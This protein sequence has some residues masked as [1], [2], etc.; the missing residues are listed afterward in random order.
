MGIPREVKYFCGKEYVEV[1]L[2]EISAKERGKKMR[3]PKRNPSTENQVKENKKRRLRKLIRLVHSNFTSDDY[4]LTLTCD[5]EHM[6][7]D[8]KEAQQKMRNFLRRVNRRLKRDG[9]T[10][11]RYIATIETGKKGT[12]FHYHFIISC[13]LSRNE[14]ED[15]WGQ[16]LANASRLQLEKVMLL[17]AYLLK[18]VREPNEKSWHCSRNLT[19]PVVRKN[20]WK[21]SHRQLENMAKNTED[22]EMWEKLYPGYE[23]IEA[24]SAYHEERGWY[25]T[26]RMRKKKGGGRTR[27]HFKDRLSL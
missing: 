26:L 22:W 11:A 15:I 27:K 21:Y 2:F 3:E 6:P 4:Y 10:P 12:N 25:V 14:L 18:E 1:D 5:P 24:S 8:K 20:D 17:C 9:Q 13:A 19:K 23:Y 7:A 16:G